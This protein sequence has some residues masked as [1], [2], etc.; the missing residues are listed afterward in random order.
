MFQTRNRKLL[1]ASGLVALIVVVVILLIVANIIPL[2]SALSCLG[3]SGTNRSF[4]IIANSNGYNDSKTLAGYSVWPKANVH[5]CDNVTF[6]IM[7]T[8]IETH[9]F[10]VGSYQ[11]EIR[12]P[13]GQTISETFLATRT[14]Q[15]R[16]YCIVI[17]SV[18]DYML[19]GQLNVT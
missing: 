15:F 17:C 3:I 11:T 10:A 8:G 16:L 4:T 7:N 9:G 14:G 6:K 13:P 5:R 1:L 19:N 2:R 18:H 12:I